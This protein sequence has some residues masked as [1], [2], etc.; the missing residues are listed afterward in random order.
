[1]LTYTLL[2]IFLAILPVTT[3]DTRLPEAAMNGDRAEVQTLLKQKV[4]A[5]E[6]QGD[7]STALHWAAYRDDVEMARLLIQAGAN[8]KAKTRIGD[9]T[10]LHLAATNGSVAMIELLLKSG[11]DATTPN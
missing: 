10:P 3:G 11:A 5:N 8:V 6:A 7:G 4:D 9:M 1:M 2:S